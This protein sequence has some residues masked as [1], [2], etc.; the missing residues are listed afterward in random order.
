MSIHINGKT[1]IS[2]HI[3][4]KTLAKAVLNVKTVYEGKKTT[5]LTFDDF[6]FYERLRKHSGGYAWT[7]YTTRA[8]GGH[9]VPNSDVNLGHVGK[10]NLGTTFG[11]RRTIARYVKPNIDV[12]K[13]NKV[14]LQA[15]TTSGSVL[16]NYVTANFTWSNGQSGYDSA[17]V[18]MLTMENDGVYDITDAYKAMVNSGTDYL[19]LKFIHPNN[20]N[21]ASNTV[22][23]ATSFN[24][25]SIII[26]HR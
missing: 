14:T 17:S 4:S 19:Y 22:A 24:I 18:S 2:G 7:G 12:D 3:D 20:E 10:I 6:L 15:S 23:W 1:F 26:E 21:D 13:I 11:Y 5:T 25:P 9:G 16:A 8:R